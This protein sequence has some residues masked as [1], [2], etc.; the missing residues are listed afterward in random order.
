MINNIIN[1]HPIPCVRIFLMNKKN[2]ILLGKRA[3]CKL[4]G[5]PGGKMEMFEEPEETAERELK[6]E[7]NILLKPSDFKLIKVKNIYNKDFGL[8][9][10]N[11]YYYAVYPEEQ[12][13]SNPEGEKTEDWVWMDENIMKIRYSELFWGIKQ[14]AKDYVSLHQMDFFFTF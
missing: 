7:T 4:Y 9:Y 11:F 2:E 10:I 14:F 5:L 6:E 1:K 13:V 3:D 12:K 8:H